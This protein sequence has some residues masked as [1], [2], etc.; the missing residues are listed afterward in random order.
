VVSVQLEHGTPFISVDI[1]GV[2]RSLILDTS[3]NIS[4]LQPDVSQSDMRVTTEKPYGVTGETLDI[5]GQQSI[6]FVLNGRE[7]NHSFLVCS[8]PTNMAGLL[9]MDFIKG[10]G[11]TIDFQYC[12]MSLTDI[13]RVP[14]TYK[15]SLT[16]H[17]ALTVFAKGKEGHSPQ[18]E[19]E[20]TWQTDEQ[21]SASPRPEDTA[22]E[23]RSWLVKAKENI[24]I[25]PRCRQIVM[26][27]LESEQN[28][29]PP[30][31]V[32]VEPAQV[33]VEGVL[34]ARKVTRVVLN[35][36]Q[37]LRLTSSRE[38]AATRSPNSCAYIMVANF[39]DESLTLPKAT[40]LGIAEEIS[41]S[42][43]DKL[44]P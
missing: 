44:P 4:I 10:S 2:S 7:F 8:L 19:Q 42:L 38:H 1:E 3:S 32:C 15:E 24:T 20:E 21:F 43:V 37:P 6:S 25:A 18:P 30:P 40:V 36:H 11:A 9:G 34:S 31:L 35:S 33:P 5:K 17:A 14:R 39:T 12:K 26:A 13:G 16:G 27:K 22:I 28:Q 41:E 23:R 29:E